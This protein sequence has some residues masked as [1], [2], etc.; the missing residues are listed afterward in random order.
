[1]GERR[2]RLAK[3]TAILW[4]IRH[5]AVV[6]VSGEMCRTVIPSLS[7]RRLPMGREKLAEGIKFIMH[8]FSSGGCRRTRDLDCRFPLELFLLVMEYSDA[9]TATVLGGR[10]RRSDMNGCVAPPH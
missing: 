4:S 6:E 1:M 5:V 8:Y 9:E 10:P 3:Y 7:L 2:K